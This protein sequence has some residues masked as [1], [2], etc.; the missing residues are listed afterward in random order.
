MP[1][2]NDLYL[3]SNSQPTP[4]A[5]TGPPFTRAAT[6]RRICCHPSQPDSTPSKC[7]TRELGHRTQGAFCLQR[8]PPS[9]GTQTNPRN[10]RNPSRTA[11]NRPK[12]TFL[13]NEP[14]L[15]ANPNKMNHLHSHDR[16]HPFRP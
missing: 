12:N 6:H 16:T 8:K 14:I 9:V 3:K 7:V 15:V 4:L 13:P 11:R 1:H 10:P 2:P 5:P